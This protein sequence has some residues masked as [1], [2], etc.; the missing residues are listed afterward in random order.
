MND[1]L[2]WKERAMD[3]Y[4]YGG[5]REAH[6]LGRTEAANFGQSA[7]IDKFDVTARLKELRKY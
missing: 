1:S 4:V 2:Q 7:A 5:V 3:T 6:W